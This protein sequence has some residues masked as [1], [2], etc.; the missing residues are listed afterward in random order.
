MPTSF[1]AKDKANP[2]TLVVID[3]DNAVLNV[4]RRLFGENYQVVTAQ[5][6]EEGLAAVVKSNPDVVIIDVGLPDESGLETFERIHRTDPRI[7]ILVISASENSDTTIEAIKLGAFEYLVKPLDF[8]RVDELVTKALAIRRL[9]CVPVRVSEHGENNH[10]TG[11]VLVGRCS[12]M[13]EVYKGI[14]RVAA[15][16]ATVLI[17]G[18]SGTGKELVARAI[19]QHSQRK[20]AKFLAVNCAAIPEALL[21]SELFG[22]ERGAFTGAESRRIGKFEQCSGGTVFLDEIGDMT[23]LSQSKVLRVLQDQRF[24]RVG[25]QET[26]KT[27]VRIIA[28]TNRDLERMVAEGEFRSDLYYRL[29]GFSINL[30]PLRVRGEDIPLLVRHYIS[31]FR[32][33]LNKDVVQ[34]DPETLRIL[35]EYPWPGNIRQLQSVLRQT[36]LQATGPMLLPD[37]LPDEVRRPVAVPSSANAHDS[38]SSGGA[39]G[40]SIEAYMEAQLKSGS[41][42]L[43]ADCLTQLERLLVTRVLQQT[44][45]NQ[46]QAARILGITR[47]F[48]R[49]KVQQLNVSIVSNVTVDDADED[50]EAVSTNAE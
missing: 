28:A 38:A 26:I 45:G 22:H 27:D 32:R 43:Y 17:R 9:M 41:T 31:R 12:E 50:E 11:D 30:P 29:K 2:T 16:N 5:T 21:E 18:E 3:D 42:S 8:P 13:Q 15:Q 1:A 4:F 40:S 36:M 6:G 39:A 14:G 10:E 20:D 7:P 33:E 34:I 47:S 35:S 24:E 44:G 37:F 23:P 48:L 49:K 46:S 25:G 19:Y